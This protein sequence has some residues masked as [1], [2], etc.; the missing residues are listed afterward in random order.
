MSQIPH[1]KKIL[2]SAPCNS[3]CIL[4]VFL[5]D[6]YK[7]GEIMMPLDQVSP[8]QQITKQSVLFPASRPTWWPKI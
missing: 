8:P 1:V 6:D 3:L 2:K 5:K 7:H 4:K